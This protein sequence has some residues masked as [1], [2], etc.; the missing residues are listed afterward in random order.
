[1]GDINGDVNWYEADPRGILPLDAVHIPHDLKR[2]L[3]QRRFK[4]TLNEAFEEVIYHCA[5]RGEPTWIT[6]EII[7]AYTTL[8][9]L[10]FAQSVEAWYEGELAGGLYGATLGGA[11]FGESM[12]HHKRDASKVALAHL[13][14]WLAASGFVLCDVQMITDVLRRFGAVHIS[15]KEYLQRLDYAINLR[16][17]LRAVEVEW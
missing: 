8:H 13:A 7:H 9:Y 5:N 4:V 1:M 14:K 2:I 12:F 6:E 16:R 3:R 17:Q 11:F 15:K 10:G